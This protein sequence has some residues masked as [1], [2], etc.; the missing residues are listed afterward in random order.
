MMAIRR[1]RAA[2]AGAMETDTPASTPEELLLLLDRTEL[3]YEIVEHEAVFTIADALAATP[4][5]GG[6]KTKNVFLRDAKGARHFLV[7][8]P[9][10]VRL[11][12]AALAQML[13]ST[14][15]SMGSPDR[16]QRHLGV[17]PGAVSVFALV[18]DRERAVELVFDERVWQADKLQAHP[19]R[20]TATVAIGRPALATF[21]AFTGHAPK[22][23]R[24]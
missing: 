10:D 20:N 12:L 23:V 6:I 14:K 9:H 15:L 17:T 22:V 13:G 16:L 5:I 3:P 11:D 1:R 7:I 8:V 18:N 4:E 19:L 24:V 21:L 2:Y